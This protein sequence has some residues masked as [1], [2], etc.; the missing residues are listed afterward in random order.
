MQ[1]E[2]EH[3]GEGHGAQEHA[4]IGPVP[5]LETLFEGGIGEDDWV[6]TRTDLFSVDDGV[7]L[8]ESEAFKPAEERVVV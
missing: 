3:G 2:G 1:P 8:V 6:R 7:A 5:V 4:S